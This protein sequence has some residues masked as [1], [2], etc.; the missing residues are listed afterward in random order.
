[1][2]PARGRIDKAE[3]INIRIGLACVN[4]RIILTG[5]KIRRNINALSAFILN[6]VGL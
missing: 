5:T 1:M 6:F 3:E 4:S 2:S